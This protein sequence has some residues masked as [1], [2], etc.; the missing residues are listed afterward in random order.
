MNMK[1]MVFAVVGCGLIGCKRIA[2]LPPESTLKYVFDIVPANAER[3]AQ[4]VDYPVT[5]ASKLEV[6]MVDQSVDVILIATSHHELASIAL[7]AVQS[8]HHVLVEKP[9]AMSRSDIEQL[10]L[11]A[12]EVDVVVH[13]GY[14]HRFHPS[15]LEAK[16]IIDSNRFGKL[17]W[18][19]GRYGHGGRPGYEKEWR[20][21]RSISGG[22]ELVDQGSHLIDI[23]RHLCGDMELVFSKTQNSFW[24]TDVED[25]VFFALQPATGGFAWMHASGTEWKNMFS[26]EITLETA[27]IDISGLGGSYGVETLTLYE[28]QPEMGPPPSTTRTW[29]ESDASWN[30][31]LEDLVSHINNS[32]YA[33]TGTTLDGAVAVWD[34]IEKAYR[35]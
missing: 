6:I 11:I 17:L 21:N 15:L 20:A 23:C 34:I 4:L 9:G 25:N 26:L 33:P 5:I 31:E 32:H 10:R 19:R 2:S 14:N 16:K 12:N 18:M 13:V 24:N 29:N 3:A 7:R 35:A 8:G 27:K 30:L 22:G 28:M 1:P